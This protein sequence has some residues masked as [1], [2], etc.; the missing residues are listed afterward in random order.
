MAKR[1]VHH[2]Q[3]AE[4]AG[5][6]AELFILVLYLI[7]GWR[8][9]ARRKRTPF[10]EIDLIVK[11]GSVICF[12][13]VKYRRKLRDFDAILSP[14]QSQRLARAISWIAAREGDHNNDVI[15]FDIAI[16]TK[17]GRWQILRNHFL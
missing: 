7:S 10:G 5:R 3:K 9:V 4:K 2:Y 8:F 15:R 14:T 17:R 11:R 13:E 12:I 1:Y 6:Y 16:V